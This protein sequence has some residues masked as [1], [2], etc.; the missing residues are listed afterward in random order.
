MCYYHGLLLGVNLLGIVNHEEDG[1]SGEGEGYDLPQKG[2]GHL[3]GS[4]NLPVSNVMLGERSFILPRPLD[5]SDSDGS[6]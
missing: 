2:Q 6:H 3:Q 1:V 4:L 5:Y